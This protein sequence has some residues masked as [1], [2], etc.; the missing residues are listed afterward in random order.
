MN[1]FSS[2]AA[3][4]LLAALGGCAS[5]S[6]FGA[7]L[8]PESP[9]VAEA[10]WPVV[11]DTPSALPPG[12]YDASAPD[13]AVGIAATAVLG[14]IAVDAASRAEALGG[15]VLTEAERRRLTRKR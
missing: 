11:V 4:M 10:P 13:P 2:T 15:P 12:A 9:G 5:A 6:L 3:F 14:L 8:V 1:G 7:D